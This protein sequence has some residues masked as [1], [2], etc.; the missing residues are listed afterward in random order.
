MLAPKF[1][2][3]GDGLVLGEEAL[4]GTYVSAPIWICSAGCARRLRIHSV[5][6]PQAEQTTASRVLGVVGERHRDRLVSFAGLA[7]L[8]GDQQERVAEKPAEAVAVERARQPHER[9]ARSVPA[10]G[11][12]RAAASPD[13]HAWCVVRHDFVT[14]GLKIRDS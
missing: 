6:G 14:G 5:F 1:E 13:A 10:A 2:P 7:A 3:N 9:R 8:V 11:A 4:L 12:A